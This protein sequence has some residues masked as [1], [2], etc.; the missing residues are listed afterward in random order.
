MADPHNLQRFVDAQAKVLD[1]VRSELRA[2]RKTSHWM[3]FVFPQIEGLGHSALAK[4]FAISSGEEAQAYLNH[5]LL[6][7]RL[8]ECVRLLLG[9]EGRTIADILGHPDDL[10]FRSSMTLF[11]RVAQDNAIFQEALDKYFAGEPD[12]RTLERLQSSQTG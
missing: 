4:H 12:R 10:K 2:G 1:A 9:V 8:I 11:S 7:P 3:W 5:S 6:G